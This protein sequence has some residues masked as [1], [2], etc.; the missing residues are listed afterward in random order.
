[1][2][3]PRLLLSYARPNWPS[4]D[5][6]R[7]LLYSDYCNAL[8][9]RRTLV[10]QRITWPKA[11]VY[12]ERHYSPSSP[13]SYHNDVHNDARSY[14]CTHIMISYWP[15]GVILSSV[16]LSLCL[17]VTECIV[18]LRVG[19]G[20]ECFTAVFLGVHFLFTSSVTFAVGCLVQPQH[21]AKNRIAKI[22]ASVI[23]VGSVFTWPTDHGYSKRG[24]TDLYIC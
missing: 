1:M 12:V 18:E 5:P 14:C 7:G 13:V 23:T 8:H 22:S 20:V 24:L 9:Q 3:M 15:R 2:Q 17:S 11:F 6:W 19:A 10:R 21:T 16:C 4:S